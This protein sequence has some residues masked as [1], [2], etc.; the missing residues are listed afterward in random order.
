LNLTPPFNI[1][2]TL[3]LL[4]TIVNGARCF[5]R[6][7]GGIKMKEKVGKVRVKTKRFHFIN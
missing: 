7:S 3:N 5:I 6:G 4:S 2:L 1:F